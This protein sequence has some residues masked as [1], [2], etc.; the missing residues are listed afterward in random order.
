MTII[1][2]KDLAQAVRSVRPSREDAV[3]GVK[4]KIER[5][6]LQGADKLV[7]LYGKVLKE[8]EKPEYE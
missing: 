4:E 3:E 8:L 2:P 6:R 7:L 1:T 5:F